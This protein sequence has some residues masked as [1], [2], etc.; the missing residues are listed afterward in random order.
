MTVSTTISKSGPYAGSGTTGPFLVDFRFLEDSHLRVVKTSAS[1]ADSTLT[2]NTDYTVSGVGGD[3]GTVTLVSALLVGEKLTII[4]SVPA[5]QEADYV[6]NDRFPSESHE[7]ALDKLTM[8]VQQNA[9]VISRALV[10]PE[11]DPTGLNTVLPSQAN[12]AGTVMVFD[13]NGEPIVGPGL[14]NVNTVAQNVANIGVVAGDINNVNTVAADIA[15][16]NTVA[17]DI[18]SVNT[19]AADIASV[20][21]V[22]TNIADVKTV[23]ANIGDI[24]EAVANLPDLAGKVSKT[25]D[26]GAAVIPSGP[27]IDQPGT[28]TPGMFRHNEDVDD[29]EGYRG[30]AWKRFS[31]A[32][33]IDYDNTGTGLTATNVQDAVS[34]LRA[35]L[36]SSLQWLGVPVGQEFHLD[37]E[38]P[39][40]PKD[41]PNF[42]YVVLTA[43]QSGAGGYN[44]GVLTS[45]TVTGSDPEITAT[46][47]VSLAESPLFNKTIDLL[48]T[49]RTFVR[50]GVGGGAIVNSQN[51]AHAH[52]ATQTQETMSAPVGPGYGDVA[53]TPG[54]IATSSSGGAEANPRYIPRTFLMRIM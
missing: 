2:L 13:E 35:S 14:G 39:L 40:P 51:R 21:T 33:N 36:L 6:Q 50:P 7:R 32:A 10:V 19:V 23:A 37:P 27:E 12:R 47:V 28:A 53:R 52:T 4:R 54:G 24:N 31:D 44:E 22:A 30:G 26:T 43:G 46:A 20:N 17:A 45:E 18:A 1:G 25:S 38:A 41:D 11:T 29:F 8:L 16:V 5:T 3:T 49:S 34:E 42:R 9:E 48:N 15:S